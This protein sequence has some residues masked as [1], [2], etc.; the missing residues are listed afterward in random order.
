MNRHSLLREALLGAALAVC[1]TLQAH[2][3]LVIGEQATVVRTVTT[4]TYLNGGIGADEQATMRR[5]AK[6]FPLRLVFSQGKD[7][8]FLADIPIVI[9][10]SSANSI[11]ALRAAGPMLYVMLPPGRYKVSAR[12]NGVTRTQQVTVSG[13]DGK[14]LYFHWEGTPRVRDVLEPEQPRATG[15]VIA[16]R[17]AP[18]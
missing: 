18:E 3:Q 5:V 17:Y 11:L 9:S 1:G 7:G 6:E 12:F 4:S 13:N 15:H 8:A 10:D 14:E 2:A 16:A